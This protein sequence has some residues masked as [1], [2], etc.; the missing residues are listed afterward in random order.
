M[1][2]KQLFEM[3]ATAMHRAMPR[4]NPQQ[5]VQWRLDCVALADALAQHN[6][7]FDRKRFYAD[8]INGPNK[9]S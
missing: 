4:R 7:T 2:R 1:T 6:S 3:L 5:N 8:C 9:E